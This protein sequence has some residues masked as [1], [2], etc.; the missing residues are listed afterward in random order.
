MLSF[1]QLLF[2]AFSI[3]S[4][5]GWVQQNSGTTSNV[6]GITFIGHNTGYALA[7]PLLKTTN[8]GLN[9]TQ[10]TG[11]PSGSMSWPDADTGYFCNNT[12]FKSTNGGMNW[13]NLNH[14]YLYNISFPSVSEGYA[15]SE[16]FVSGPDITY[17][18]V[19][20]S[21]NGAVNWNTCLEFSTPNTALYRYILLYNQACSPQVAYTAVWFDNY[22]YHT[23]W[24]RIYRTQNGGGSWDYIVH[25]NDTLL[26]RSFH[27]PSPN[28]GY[29]IA[30]LLQG[31]P[32][33]FIYKYENNTLRH[34]LTT[35]SINGLYFPNNNT[36]YFARGVNEMYKTTNGGDNWYAISPPFSNQLY[37]FYFIDHLT[38][39]AVGSNGAIAKTTTGGEM[40]VVYSISGT[41]R[42]QDNNDP[43]TGGYVKA[44]R[45]DSVSHNIITV[46]STQIQ[47][48]GAYTLPNCPPV[49]LDIMA[50]ENDEEELSF[51]PTYHVSTINWQNSTKVKPD[52]NLTNINIAVKR[53]VNPGDSMHVSGYIYTNNTSDLSALKDA[54]IYSRSSGIFKSH[55]IS[56][57]NGYYCVDS[58]SA[59]VYEFIVYRMGYVT[60]SIVVSLTNSSLNNI[61]FFLDDILVAINPTAME[62]PSEF[63]LKQNFPNP[64]NPVTGIEFSVP[65]NSFAKLTVYDVL[66]REVEVLVD[67][68]LQRGVYRASWNAANHPSGV[69]FYRLTAGDF[70][71]AK[72]MIL[73]K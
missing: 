40:P 70:S 44:L 35:T 19:K 62:I 3:F 65:E 54:I 41:I 17:F 12:V 9:W 57:Q 50:Y 18:R 24:S 16:E 34:L 1:I 33:R 59:G 49:W 42:F 25:S 23:Y 58:L 26:F 69:Y 10:M 63:V 28:V 22:E 38:G 5:T 73:I 67:Q 48:S 27:F 60:E 52:S 39:F 72:K 6:T 55:S 21:N 68:Q 4:Q 32:T 43:V 31:S 46:D 29:I 30:S 15:L 56:L 51:V 64:F 47:S 2:V 13:V 37:G 7:T 20:K 8:G 14:N 36:G 71:D 45:Y 66:G 53:I 11:N 61:N